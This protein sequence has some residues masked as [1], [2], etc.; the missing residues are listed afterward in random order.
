MPTTTAKP[1]NS[2][3]IQTMLHES[4][5]LKEISFPSSANDN[6]KL[7]NLSFDGNMRIN[8]GSLAV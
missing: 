6:A 2:F 8:Y 3:L 4:D 1:Q 5:P 7:L